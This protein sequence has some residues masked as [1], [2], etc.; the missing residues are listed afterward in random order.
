MCICVQLL[1]HLTLTSPECVLE[2][3]S[4]QDPFQLVLSVDKEI[5]SPGVEAALLQLLH[6]QES[7]EQNY[8]NE[9]V[10]QPGLVRVTSGLPA[11]VSEGY[12]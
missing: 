4:S 12:K 9:V 5:P 7:T 10:F 2:T 1:E 11:W 8:V 3:S 6:Q